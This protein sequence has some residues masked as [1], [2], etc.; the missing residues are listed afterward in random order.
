MARGGSIAALFTMCLALLSVASITGNM[1]GEAEALTT[2]APICIEGDNEFTSA[3]GVTAGTGTA[4]NPYIIEGWAI[5][6]SEAHGVRIQDTTAHFVIR[7]MSAFDGE[8]IEDGFGAPDGIS[9]YNVSNGRV[10]NVTVE[11]CRYGVSVFYSQDVVV[12]GVHASSNNFSGICFHQSHDVHAD[13]NCMLSNL[14]C[15][16]TV[17]WCSDGTVVNN[18]VMN[19]SHGGYP[20]TGIRAM[21]SD[22]VIISHNRLDGNGNSIEL[23]H[24]HQL[25]ASF[26]IIEN[27]PGHALYLYYTEN[28]T[29]MGNSVRNASHCVAVQGSSNNSVFHNNFYSS[30][31]NVVI[32]ASND[33]DDGY[34][35][36]GN[37]WAAYEGVDEYSGVDQDT[38]GSDGIGDDEYIIGGGLV[39]RFPLMEPINWEPS[40][41]FTVDPSAGDLDT[42]FVV[43]ASQCRDVEDWQ[44]SLEVR[45]D[46]ED[47]GVWDTE[48]TPNKVAEHQYTSEGQFTIRLEVRDTESA[49]SDAVNQVLVDA[50]PPSTDFEVSGTV[51]E[52][53]WYTSALEVA[54]S[55]QDEWSDV[56]ATSYSLNGTGWADYTGAIAIENDGSH[57][58]EFFSE[59][60]I[61]NIEEVVNI[62]LNVDMTAPEVGAILT[63]GGISPFAQ[64]QSW[65]SSE[66]TV[67]IPASDDAS[68]I[69]AIMYRVDGGAWQNYSSALTISSSGNHTID[70]YAVDAAGNIGDSVTDHVKVDI[71]QPMVM[72]TSVKEGDLLLSEDILL[73]WAC[74]E[75]HSGIHQFFV[76]VD[77][78]SYGLYEHSVNETLISALPEGEHEIQVLAMDNAG[79]IGATIVHFSVTDPDIVSN[80]ILWMGVGLAATVAVIVVVYLALRSRRPSA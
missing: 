15:G 22:N 28:S 16:M 26:N 5:N 49:T 37:Y 47:D 71:V 40:A 34:P 68:G 20:F 60:S 35:S 6:A 70:Y 67:S 32:T 76:N 10:E 59:D 13:G 51:G 42:V 78:V 23:F 65:Y 25:I 62:S 7:N 4:E 74:S 46:W 58:L 64:D 33:F 11:R 55:A 8:Y 80:L 79:N 54:L 44:E 61:G 18:I 14:H 17:G 9:L 43:D 38:P 39:D 52:N 19:T 24:S 36:G 2:R 48:W 29:I 75:A 45:W 63:S 57:I 3:N 69:D 66:A 50:T 30:W 41:G 53:G 72:V 12:T 1:A 56:V 77:G 27:D 73:T 31:V 21:E